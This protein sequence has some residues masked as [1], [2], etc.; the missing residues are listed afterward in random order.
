MKLF[1]IL[2]IPDALHSATLALPEL[3]RG[4]QILR[5]LPC[6]FLVL[7]PPLLQPGQGLLR[8]RACHITLYQFVPGHLIA[9]CHLADPPASRILRRDFPDPRFRTPHSPGKGRKQVKKSRVSHPLFLAGLRKLSKCQ[10]HGELDGNRLIRTGVPLLPR[11]SSVLGVLLLMTASLVQARSSVVIDSS[12]RNGS[13]VFEEL[14][15]A[16][17]GQRSRPHGRTSQQHPG[18]AFFPPA[19]QFR[20]SSC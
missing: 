3:P 2:L 13:L 16:T 8:E 10:V 9:S 18:R 1:T 20:S 11:V 7:L 4:D 6:K 12:A 19:G 15:P 17:P 14:I 5:E